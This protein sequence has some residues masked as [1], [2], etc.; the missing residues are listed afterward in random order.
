MIMDPN[1]EITGSFTGLAWAQG[2]RLPCRI[3][4]KWTKSDPLVVHIDFKTTYAGETAVSTWGVSRA[5][6]A[7]AMLGG[8]PDT[9][10]RSWQR[11]VVM[12]KASGALMLRLTSPEGRAI[13]QCPGG[14][15]L[16]FLER[17]EA[18]VG[19]GS[20]E[21]QELVDHLVDAGIEMIM[22]REE[23]P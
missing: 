16:G 3:D 12:W 9:D 2:H 19:S 1:Q 17:T 15:T 20:P 21:E 10:H 22:K 8:K 13:V 5:E 11:D 6:M 18:V 4:M 14:A 7:L 23:R